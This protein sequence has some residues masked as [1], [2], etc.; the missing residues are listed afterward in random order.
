MLF[1]TP[2]TLIAVVT[3]GCSGDEGLVYQRVPTS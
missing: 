3:T 2:V 1:D